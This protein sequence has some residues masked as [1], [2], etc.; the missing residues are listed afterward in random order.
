MSSVL[1]RK[2]KK[3]QPLGYT[4][5]ELRWNMH[6]DYKLRRAAIVDMQ[7]REM[8]QE[9]QVNTKALEKFRE[10][11]FQQKYAE[12]LRNGGKADDD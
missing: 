11:P 10:K 9:K 1:N 2:K 4:K 8:R 7:M 3:M 6:K 12:M 5:Q